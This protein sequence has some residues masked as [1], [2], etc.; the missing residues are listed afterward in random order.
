VTDQGF[1]PYE[2]EKPLFLPP[3]MRKWAPE[4]H[5]GVY[6]S[7]VADALDLSEIAGADSSSA[8]DSVWSLRA[9]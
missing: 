6:V 2:P 7:D 4:D 8:P 9:T 1:K 3:H 5:L